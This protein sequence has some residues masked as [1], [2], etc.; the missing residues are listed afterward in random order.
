MYRTVPEIQALNLLGLMQLVDSVPT[1]GGYAQCFQIND[2]ARRGLLRS[3]EQIGQLLEAGLK[4]SIGPSDGVAVGWAFKAARQGDLAELPQLAS[5]LS[6]PQVSAD[7]RVA[8][9]ELGAHLW[10][11]SRR[12]DWAQAMHSQVDS[13][14]LPTDLHHAMAFGALVSE[15]T[16]QEVRAIAMC[17]FSAAKAIIRAAVTAI[18][19]DEAVILKLLSRLQPEIADMAHHY[20]ACHPETIHALSPAKVVASVVDRW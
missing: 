20:A 6:G 12:W 3:E 13:L 4:S 16:A 14:A 10:E 15:T 9:L 17:L 18:P 1:I 19:L 8:S 5:C 2:L 7:I 11:L